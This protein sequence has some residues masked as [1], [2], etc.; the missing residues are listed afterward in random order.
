MVQAQLLLGLIYLIRVCFCCLFFLFFLFFVFCIDDVIYIYINCLFE[1]NKK[2]LYIIYIYIHS[3][4][5]MC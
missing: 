5:T 1:E 4:M 2:L 3:F